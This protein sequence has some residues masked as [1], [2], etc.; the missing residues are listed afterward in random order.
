MSV[1]A[2]LALAF[3][4]LLALAAGIIGGWTVRATRAS[5]VEQIDDRMRAQSGRPIGPGR[6]PPVEDGAGSDEGPYR[7]IAE[8]QL[9]ADG[10]VR[11]ESP[12]GFPDDPEPTPDLPDVD[13]DEFRSDVDRIVTRSSDGGPDYR[14][15]VRTSRDGGYRVLATPLSTVD[16][17]VSDLV[18]T[19]VVT[20]IV[21]V[22]L[23]AAIAWWIV[24]RGLRPVDRM[25]DTA[26]AIAAGDLSQRVE[27][28]SDRS[29]LGRLATALDDMLAQLESAFAEREA[30]QARLEQFVADA[31][32]ELRTPVAAIRGYAELYRKGGLSEEEALARAMA[33]IEGESERMG[34]LVED[35]LLLARLDQHQQLEADP[36]DL[37]ELAT[38]AVSDLRAVEPE[39]PV[40]LDAPGPVVVHGDER[41]LRQVLGNLLGNARVHTPPGTPVHV[42]VAAVDGTARVT[43][44]DEGPGIAA[45]HRRRIFERF[46]RADRSR[47]RASGGAGLGLSIVAGVV[48]AHDGRVEVDSPAGGGTTFTVQLPRS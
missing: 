48:A 10:T 24:R 14:V 9:T 22:G 5:L 28:K 31:S 4:A 23:G 20:A 26:S 36:V 45:D 32:H 27:H 12:A 43:V 11:Q 42:A 37:T 47:A 44:A 25:V 40:T 41:R 34:R 6:E 33:R 13:S 35:L 1:K 15:L 29:E 21:V 7:P 16:A 19:V 17:T 30:S 46:Y 3:V 39:R 18:R 8:I 2:R 38:D